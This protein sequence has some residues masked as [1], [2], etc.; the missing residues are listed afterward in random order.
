VNLTKHGLIFWAVVGV[1]AL[2][3]ASPVLSRL[4]VY[5]RTEFLTELWLLGPNHKAEDYP[6]SITRGQSYS[7]FLGVAN[8]LGYAAYYLVEVKFRNATQSGPTSFGPLSNR[9][10]SSLPSLYNIYAFV[11]DEQSW[12]LPVQFSF[13]YA[14]DSASSVVYFH[15]MTFNGAVLNMSSYVA[16]WN[17][18]TRRVFGSLF[19]EMWIYNVTS[20][21]FQYH[22]RFVSLTF[23]VTVS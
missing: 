12:E 22:D 3:A 6:Y 2:L 15:S 17:S 16:A 18:T 1:L 9:T 4:L 20:S 21:V 8:H 13:D 19:F 14:Y 23:N 5:P 11:P 7:V 10:A